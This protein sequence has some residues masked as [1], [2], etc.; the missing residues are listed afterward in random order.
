MV[1]HR[2]KAGGTLQ[3]PSGCSTTSLLSADPLWV[4]FSVPAGPP[5][6][7]AVSPREQ[8]P[9][10]APRQSPLPTFPSQPRFQGLSQEFPAPEA[11]GVRVPTPGPAPAPL[12]ADWGILAEPITIPGPPP[13]ALTLPGPNSHKGPFCCFHAGCGRGL[14]RTDCSKLGS[15]L[16]K[17]CWVMAHAQQPEPASN[18]TSAL[19]PALLGSHQGWRTPGSP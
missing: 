14:W 2:G 13:A 6:C 5:G 16:D 8:T 12:C 18:A 19:S 10:S 1:P 9:A 7:S 11:P 17:P 3:V 4:L 15:A